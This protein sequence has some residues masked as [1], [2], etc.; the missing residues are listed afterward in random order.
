MSEAKSNGRPTAAAADTH[1]VDDEPFAVNRGAAAGERT[2]ERSSERPIKDVV[3]TVRMTAS[4]AAALAYVQAELGA[5]SGPD[6]IRE[7]L[8]SVAALLKEDTT[9][10][11]RAQRPVVNVDEAQLVGIHNAIGEV[12]TSYNK[13]TR[14]LHFIGHNFNQLTKV[15]NATGKVDTDAL[16][17]VER[18]LKEI[19]KQMAADAERDT[20]TLEVL[21]C[22]L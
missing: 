16:G 7:S 8:R 12:T 18:A 19:R 13:R 5:T 6:A 4:D 3:V 11:S 20:K 22:L 21:S 10:S 1:Q 9:R 14:E 17:G 15:A 2:D